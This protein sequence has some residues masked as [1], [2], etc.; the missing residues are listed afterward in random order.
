MDTQDLMIYCVKDAG[1][2]YECDELRKERN[3]FQDQCIA[4]KQEM[5]VLREELEARIRNLD[6]EIEV[7]DN[8]AA[9]PSPVE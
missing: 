3:A 7:A 9:N 2:I 1:R 6:T 4:L 8:G 5:A